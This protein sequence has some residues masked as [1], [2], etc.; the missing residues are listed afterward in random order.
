MTVSKEVMVKA[1]V[2]AHG[3]ELA[4][5]FVESYG[6][7]LLEKR[8]GYGNQDPSEFAGRRIPQELY[9]GERSLVAAVNVRTD[10]PWRL[11]FTEG[12]AHLAG[13]NAA[14]LPV[15]FP[16][17]PR[18]YGLMLSDGTEA[19]RVATLYGGHSLAI[20]G[21]SRCRMISAGMPCGF[22]S[23][24]VNAS[25]QQHFET[26]VTPEQVYEVV[27]MALDADPEVITQVMI[28]GGSFEDPDEGFLY[29]LALAEA[30]REAINQVGSEAE[31]HLITA[32][33]S[34]RSLLRGLDGLG[35]SLAMNLEALHPSV[36]ASVCPGKEALVGQE[37]LLSC[38]DEAVV[39]LGEGR[40]YSLLVGGLEST[41]ATIRAIDFL[42]DRGVVPVV[43]ILHRD[44]GTP[45]EGF[46]PVAVEFIAAVG[47]R[48]QDTY[49][50]RGYTPFYG[51]CGRNS[52]D[53]EAYLGLF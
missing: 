14:L 1:Q 18:F 15:Q 48:L 28:N 5:E 7:E 47:R 17:R 35:L 39:V 41:V 21:R 30:G 31:L 51:K 33:P 45:C 52:I 27:S 3:L 9:L 29:Y 4:D 40:V 16:M 37:H 10:S 53:Y 42:A 19:N 22:C 50:G 46:P 36:F 20:F 11:I 25:R 49:A 32:P 43:N 24:G 44:P 8:R 12:A 23:L 6:A 34:R 38:L 13:P 2:L 26:E